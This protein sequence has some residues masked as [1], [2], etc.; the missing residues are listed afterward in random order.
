MAG[1]LR[2]PSWVDGSMSDPAMLAARCSTN[3]QPVFPQVRVTVVGDGDGEA[4]SCMLHDLRKLGDWLAGRGRARYA[5]I[6]LRP[7][8]SITPELW[9]E[10]F[11]LLNEAL[12]LYTDW[13]CCELA[14][15]LPAGSALPERDT[16]RGWIVDRTHAAENVHAEEHQELRRLVL[17]ACPAAAPAFTLID[18]VARGM[19]EFLSGAV[20]GEELLFAGADADA[21][22]WEAYFAN[23]NPVYEPI[24]RLTAEVVAH[25]IEERCHPS[26]LRVLEVGA[27]CGSATEAILR[28]NSSVP[29]AVQVT[30]ISPAFLCVA[31]GRARRVDGHADTSLR[32]SMLDL[33]RPRSWR[34][35]AA[36]VDCVVAVNVVHAVPNV[37]ATLEALRSLLA[38][39]GTLVVSECIRSA[40]D[41]SVHP[42]FIF[43]VLDRFRFVDRDQGASWGF[44]TAPAWQELLAEAGFAEIGVLP[45]AAA[46]TAAYRHHALASF[47]AS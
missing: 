5:N 44:L 29:L 18:R 38:E 4:G 3:R 8:R 47:V 37:R 7:F 23:D 12:D 22:A 35:P 45:D 20:S 46:A 40:P 21:E 24:N 15:E 13:R 41:C 14:G 10:E 25:L 16:V 9:T 43:S 32:F 36:S 33:D 6:D 17:A 42:E 28:R 11:F 30:D 19:E 39:G 26:P 34:I 2:V 1:T 27:G 31:G